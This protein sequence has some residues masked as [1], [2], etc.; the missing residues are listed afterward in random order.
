MSA[1]RGVS[2][3]ATGAWELPALHELWRSESSSAAGVAAVRELMATPPRGQESSFDG[4]ETAVAPRVGS[5][6]EDDGYVVTITT[7][8]NADASYAVVFDASD[9]ARGP[10][11][12]LKLPE[13]VSSG[14]HSTWA[15]SDD[16]PGWDDVEAPESAIGL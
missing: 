3:R 2:L 12:K 14:T 13:R 1:G 9:I 11:C 7:D 6:A 4:S 15:A 5:T 10:V 16:L 8:M